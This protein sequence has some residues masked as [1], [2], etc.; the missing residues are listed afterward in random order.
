MR[1]GIRLPPALLLALPGQRHEP[2][3]F[4]VI[5]NAVQVTQVPNVTRCRTTL[6]SLHPADLGWRAQQFRGHLIDRQ[7]QII[8]QRP[9]QYAQFA[10]ANRG[11]TGGLAYFR[12][13]MSLPSSSTCTG[14]YEP[15]T[16]KPW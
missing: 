13:W 1:Q 5:G 7:A 12:H 9:Q 8:T 4:G 6:A 16:R 14:F 15:C 11:A 10:P 3:P 2:I